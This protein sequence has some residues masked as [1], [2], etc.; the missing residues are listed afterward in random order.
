MEKIITHSLDSSYFGY[1]AH[2][3]PNSKPVFFCIDL[4]AIYSKN[5]HKEPR[6]ERDD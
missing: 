1:W 6:H 4:T 5:P 2:I 3:Y